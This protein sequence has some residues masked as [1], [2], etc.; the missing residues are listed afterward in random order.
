MLVLIRI[1]V[2]DASVSW[3]SYMSVLR[4]LAVTLRSFR[5]APLF[6]GLVVA[7]LGV[8]IGAATL[9]FSIADGLVLNPFPYPEPGR[10]VGVGTAYPKLGG[11]LR[12]WEHLS[13]L[14]YLD[15]ADQSTLTDVVA[16]DMG[17]RQ[18]DE[19]GT[20]NVFT[21]FWWGDAFP[22]LRMTPAV[23]RGFRPDEIGQ[24]AQVAIV[25]HRLWQD[26]F[27][28]DPDLVGEPIHIAGDPYTLVGVMPAGH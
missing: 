18:I 13:P 23:G 10:L 7:T 26:R 9:V 1:I 15:L 24:G 3:R 4:S 20:E 21:A 11:E 12:F 5:S 28:A 17:N 16:W 25:S 14:E 2:S 6:T 19:L 8:G 22:T 27:R